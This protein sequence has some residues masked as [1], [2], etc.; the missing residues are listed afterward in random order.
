MRRRQTPKAQK[1]PAHDARGLHSFTAVH[2]GLSNIEKRSKG[3]SSAMHLAWCTVTSATSADRMMTPMANGSVLG[4]PR[5]AMLPLM[6]KH[7]A[8]VLGLG[9][10]TL[11]LVSCTKCG[12]FWDQG[13]R[14]CRSDA[15]R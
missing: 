3:C 12:W 1:C 14:S 11:R 6:V 9:V 8:L 10:L 13:P 4:R 15:P 5:S 7:L 2:I